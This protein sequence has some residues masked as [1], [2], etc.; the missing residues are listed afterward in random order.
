MRVRVRI[1]MGF[2]THLEPQIDI[3]K[4]VFCKQQQ[5]KHQCCESLAWYWTGKFMSQLKSGQQVAVGKNQ[6]PARECTP[7]WVCCGMQAPYLL[8]CGQQ[9]ALKSAVAVATEWPTVNL[10]K[11]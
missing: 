3:P 5:Q 10:A 8:A 7:F 11:D 6:G 2:A 9:A 1:P 4:I